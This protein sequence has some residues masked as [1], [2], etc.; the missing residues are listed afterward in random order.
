MH[1]TP[2]GSAKIPSRRANHSMAFRISD[3]ETDSAYPFDSFKALRAKGVSY[4]HLPTKPSAIDLSLLGSGRAFPSLNAVTAG[5]PAFG[6]VA[7]ILGK[8]SIS[9]RFLSSLKP[10]HIA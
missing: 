1:V 5:A 4:P 6:P 3:S 7:I 8:F 10:F 9:P 2:E